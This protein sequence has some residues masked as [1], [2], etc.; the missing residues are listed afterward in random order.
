LGAIVF[1]EGAERVAVGEDGGKIRKRGHNGLEGGEVEEIEAG[2]KDLKSTCI[3]I[4]MG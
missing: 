1:C 2:G 4:A 3:S